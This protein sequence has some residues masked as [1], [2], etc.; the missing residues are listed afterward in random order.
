MYLHSVQ[1]NIIP[2]YELQYYDVK[3]RHVWGYMFFLAHSHMQSQM[4]HLRFKFL[5]I[6]IIPPEIW[7]IPYSRQTEYR[8]AEAEVNT[9]KPIVQCAKV[10]PQINT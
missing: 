4:L 2:V 8:P 6:M 1:E 9:Y 7:I 10:D 3:K 5:T